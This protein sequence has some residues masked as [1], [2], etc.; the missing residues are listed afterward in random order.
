MTKK[1]F[2][3]CLTI[4]LVMQGAASAKKTELA[5]EDRIKVAI[6]VTDHSRYKELDT[7]TNFENFL[8]EKLV[9]K[10]L[11]TVINTK[12]DKDIPTEEIKPFDE[13]VPVE[14]SSDEIKSAD[15]EVP[16]DPPAAKIG[17][18]LTF[19]AIE[20]PQHGTIPENFDGDLYKN[21]GVDYVIR[22]EVLGLGTSQVEDKT[23]GTIFN[24]V[25][26][27]LSFSGNGSSSRDK[28]L[29]RVGTGIG[30]GG[31][32]QTKRTALNAVVNMQFIS[33]ESGEILWEK[34]FIGQAVRHH[35]PRKGYS[36]VWT[37]AYLES[38][39]D[40]AKRI[41][42][43]VNK[44]VDKVIIQGKSDKDFQPNVNIGGFVGGKFS[45]K[46]F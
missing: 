8:N 36:D 1:F 29:R 31:F 10:N 22:C 2:L 21:A 5:E 11:I 45:G 12:P 41:S 37:E 26:A 13:N 7:A 20:L 42:K 14:I 38:V 27:T 17:E 24:L 33:V 3:L 32:I 19:G 30:L 34:N 44:Y 39:E 46:L 40:S 18:L 28:T 23:I 25:G 16:A 4:L 15:A 35:K 9:E 43:R 6:E